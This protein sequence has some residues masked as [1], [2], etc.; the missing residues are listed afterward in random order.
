MHLIL[1][2][3]LTFLSL[4]HTQNLSSSNKRG[5]I[6]V[7]SEN[8]SD[9][10][11]WNAETSPLTWYY[12]YGAYPTSGINQNKLQFVPMMWGNRPEDA[13]F[14]DT[15]KGLIDSG[16]NIEYVL[17]FNEPDGCEGGGS[18]IDARTAARIWKQEIEPLKKHGVRL[19]AP[20]VRGG[21]AAWLQEFYTYCAGECTTDF[22]PAHYYGDSAGLAGWVGYLS[23]TYQNMTVWVTEFAYPDGP[24]VA[25]QE[26]FNE[27]ITFLDEQS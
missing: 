26:S 5:L 14:Y 17:G 11:I 7:W 15:V 1:Y 3:F 16:M 9:D 8:T 22:M 13:G 20:A 10:D 21:G 23:A 6:Y 19:G 2:A 24:L 12:N 18:C 27:S 4:V 25:T